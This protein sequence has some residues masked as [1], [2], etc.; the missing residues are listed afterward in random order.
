MVRVEER[1]TVGSKNAGFTGLGE[2]NT[3]WRYGY[4]E[5]LKAELREVIEEIRMMIEICR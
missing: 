2:V 3:G 1:A 4:L 5:A